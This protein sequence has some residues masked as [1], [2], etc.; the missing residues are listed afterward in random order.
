MITPE[1]RKSTIHNRFTNKFCVIFSFQVSQWWWL[2]YW[3]WY[4]K[5]IIS[6]WSMTFNNGWYQLAVSDLQS[7]HFLEKSWRRNIQLLS[8]VQVSSE[9]PPLRYMLNPQQPVTDSWSPEHDTKNTGEPKV[10]PKVGPRV[11]RSEEMHWPPSFTAQSI[12]H[13]SRPSTYW[14]GGGWWWPAT[15]VHPFRM[16]SEAIVPMSSDQPTWNA[17]TNHQQ[18]NRQLDSSVCLYV[19]PKGS[20]VYHDQTATLQGAGPSSLFRELRSGICKEK[21][22][23]YGDE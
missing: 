7:S 11:N 9:A 2:S 19:G 17:S 1:S 3:N 15:R 4:C 22:L 21:T 18:V 5:L 14:G 20:R 10:G 13:L 16:G 12:H 23:A 8:G 6:W